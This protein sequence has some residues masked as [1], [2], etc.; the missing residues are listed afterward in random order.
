MTL[1][2]ATSCVSVLYTPTV[3]H[4]PLHKEKGELKGA[5]NVYTIEY[6]AGLEATS[7]YSITNFCALGMGF[8][9][10]VDGSRNENRGRGFL[11]EPNINLS[12]IFI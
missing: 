2:G 6:T 11:A 1:F 4:V 8:Q 10:F 3:Q 9:S 7:S 12:S 5:T